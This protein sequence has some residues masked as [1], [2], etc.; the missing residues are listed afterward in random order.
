MPDRVEEILK[1]I[2]VMFA[3]CPPVEGTPDKVII[4]KQDMFAVLEELNEAIYAV[5]DRYEAT[6]RSREKAKLEFDKEAAQMVAKA[7]SDSDDVHAA[8]LLYTDRMLGDVRNILEDTK[9]D[10]RN[11]LIELMAAIEHEQETLDA[12]KEGVKDEL[13]NL[14]DGERYLQVLT[15]IREKE[16]YQKKTDG[17]DEIIPEEKKTAEVR[18]K[19]N[20]PGEN[21][22]VTMS[23]KHEWKNRKKTGGKTEEDDGPIQLEHPLDD[24][25]P[26][27]KGTVFTKDDFNLDAE[28][29]Q[30]KSEQEGTSAEEEPQTKKGAFIG[31]F[32]DKKKKS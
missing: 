10:V 21:T 6:T 29:E 5:L 11:K 27:P 28:Y 4:S 12:N 16:Q 14:H 20:K 22:G 23:S 15:E 8:T 13:R 30:W 18:I 25:N 7:K 24:E 26:T 17:E 31:R 9:Q 1:K 32:F 2:H 19:V 3:Q